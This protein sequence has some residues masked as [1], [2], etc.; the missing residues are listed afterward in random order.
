MTQDCKNTHI[1]YIQSLYATLSNTYLSKLNIGKIC[2]EAAL[3]L[4][5]SRAYLSSLC[6]YQVFEEDVTFAYS[7]EITRIGEDTVDISIT[8]D[9]ETVTYSGTGDLTAILVYFETQFLTNGTYTFQVYIS[10][11]ILYIYSYDIGLNFGSTV[12]VSS[13]DTD[14]ATIAE[15]NMENTYCTILDQWNCLTTEELCDII[16]HSHSILKGCN[17]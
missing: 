14:E 10:E 16:C 8:I 1:L 13:S 11:D 9:T 12:T 6:D 15:T 3:N 17:C 4:D 2:K 7:F 5:I